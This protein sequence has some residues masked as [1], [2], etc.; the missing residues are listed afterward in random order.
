MH[1]N[2]FFSAIL[3]Y[4]GVEEGCGELFVCG[5]L[6]FSVNSVYE[7]YTGP[8]QSYVHPFAGGEAFVVE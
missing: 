4:G 2:K 7:G 6:L 1:E 8:L 3:V 5:M